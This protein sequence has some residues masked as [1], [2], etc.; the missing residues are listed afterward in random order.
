MYYIQTYYTDI[1]ARDM[2]GTGGTS[3]SCSDDPNSRDK[4]AHLALG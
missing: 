4:G 3:P 1:R 2:G